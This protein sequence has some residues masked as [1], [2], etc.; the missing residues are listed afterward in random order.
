MSNSDNSKLVVRYLK[1]ELAAARSG[2]FSVANQFVA[3]DAS[4]SDPGPSASSGLAAH[5][6][7]WQDL[8][9]A[10]TDLAFDIHDVIEAGD[11]VVARWS[12][13]GVHGGGFSGI[14]PTGHEVTMTGI[15][16]YRTADDKVAE[17]WSSYDQLGMLE[18]LGVVFQDDDGDYEN[19]DPAFDLG[20]II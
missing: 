14:A 18:Q 11:R 8:V 3:E 19:P 2:D 5:Q 13:R 10:F 17:A 4:F 7:R 9:G 1:A 12:M 20:M 15:T 16:I 6:Q